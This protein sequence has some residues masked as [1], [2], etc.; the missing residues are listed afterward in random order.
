[1][2][3]AMRGALVG[4]RVEPQHQARLTAMCSSSNSNDNVDASAK[5][6]E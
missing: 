6:E 4:R 3:V 5:K 1:M 2:R